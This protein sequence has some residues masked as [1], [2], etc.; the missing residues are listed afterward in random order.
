MGPDPV[1]P[2]EVMRR[3]LGFT[4]KCNGKYI[5]S[6]LLPVR[7]NKS[8]Q[9]KKLEQQ[10][11]IVSQFLRDRNLGAVELAAVILTGR[12]STSKF[13][14]KAVGQRPQVLASPLGHLQPGS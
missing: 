1:G 12:G 3:S 14:H 5:S 2:Q 13:T 4:F 7:D 9:I 11:F 10:T 8:P 6:L